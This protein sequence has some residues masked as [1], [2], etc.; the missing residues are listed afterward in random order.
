MMHPVLSIHKNFTSPPQPAAEYVSATIS[1]CCSHMILAFNLP[2]SLVEDELFK[3]ML[4]NNVIE[5]L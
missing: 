1:R 3:H 5:I 4:I 2:F